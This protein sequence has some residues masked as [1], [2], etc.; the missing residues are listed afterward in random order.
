MLVRRPDY[1]EKF[2]CLA[3]DCPDTCCAGWDIVIDEESRAFYQTLPGPL[4]ERIRASI[5]LD[6]DGE[7]CFSVSGGH[8]PLLTQ[9]RLC[10]IQLELGEERVCAVCREHPR[11][12]EEYGFLREESLAASC[13]AVTAL[14]LAGPEPARFPAH[15]TP[16]AEFVC[17]DV[18]L[19]LLRA[20]LP[21]REQ[22]LALVQNRSRPLGARL[23]VLL[24][25]AGQWQR[26]LEEEGA[27]ALAALPPQESP[28]PRREETA[29]QTTAAYLLD[30]LGKLELLDPA[31]GILTAQASNFCRE[32]HPAVYT[33]L[34]NEFLCA[35]TPWAW[36]YEHLAAYFLY[37]WF[38]KADFDGDLYAKAA[39]A[40][41]SCLAVEELGFVRW[42]KNGRVLEKP[43]RLEL[44]RRWCKEQEHCAENLA[45][46]ADWCWSDPA[47]SPRRLI[48]ALLE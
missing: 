40:A 10:A 7:S 24:Q 11:F 13:P 34:R 32:T 9:D 29:R 35:Q 6:E 47:L 8:C 30:R 37:R 26:V 48:S 16:E 36:E 2:R 46:L 33:A 23:G 3:G 18:D 25:T 43:D 15:S 42:V 28:F 1:Y 44:V 38:L 20:L 45:A 22:A 4:G 39:L 21:L 19:P 27:D 5:T 41:V 12:L 17:E 14:L 31:W